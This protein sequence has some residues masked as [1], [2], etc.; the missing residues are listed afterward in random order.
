MSSNKKRRAKRQAQRAAAK[1]I[2][3]T[4]QDSTPKRRSSVT[5]GQSGGT[6]HIA[7]PP[8]T[9]TPIKPPLSFLVFADKTFRD[10]WFYVAVAFLVVNLTYT[11]R[12]QIATQVAATQNDDPLNTLYSVYNPGAWTLY[13]VGM[14]C[15]VWNGQ[16]RL[17][18]LSNNT[19]VA[20]RDAPA[21]G[22]PN[23]A[24][25]SPGEMA[26]RDCGTGHNFIT[27]GNLKPEAIRIDLEFSYDWFWGLHR[28][29]T[30]RHFNTRRFQD[31]IILVPDVEG[32]GVSPPQP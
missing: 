13:N 10:F 3:N 16:Q 4:P 6:P 18:T 29:T 22:N 19:L 24:I 25:L 30:T 7:P 5:Y 20:S 21:G 11:F 12:P 32:H 27:F 15:V 23:I 14:T 1:P 2:I 31:H 17:A 9:I 26:T 8:P 28:S